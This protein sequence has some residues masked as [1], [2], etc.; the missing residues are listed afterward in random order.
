MSPTPGWPKIPSAR[1]RRSSTPCRRRALDAGDADFDASNL[2]IVSVDVG[3][4]AS[5]V[6]PGEAR[7]VFNVRFN[8]LWTPQDLSAEIARRVA[9]AAGNTRYELTFDPTNALAFL[10]QRGPFTDLVAAAVKDA[11]GVN[12]RLSTSGGTS[13]ARFIS[14]V[15][16]VVELGLVG[17]TM[18]A[19]DERVPLDD[20]D[21]PTWNDEARQRYR[22]SAPRSMPGAGENASH[23]NFAPRRQDAVGEPDPVRPAG[24]EHGVSWKTPALRRFGHR[25]SPKDSGV[26]VA[27]PASRRA[28]PV[29]IV[30]PSGEAARS[31]EQIDV[32]GNQPGS[33]SR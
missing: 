10:T 8:D 4:P 22:P 2:E 18:H 29:A 23:D 11:T 26:H 15:C 14:R 1:W 3:N 30:E 33:T 25:W 9:A 20:L 17:A 32:A 24:D 27:R 21:G 16:P 19:V 5:N 13:D 31:G 7:L 6:I 28:P 12:P